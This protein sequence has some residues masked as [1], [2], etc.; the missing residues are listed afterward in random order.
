MRVIVVGSGVVG[1]TS[2]YYMARAGAEVVVLD[3]NPEPAM[4]ASFA[5]AGSMTASRSGPWASPRTLVKALKGYF[6]DDAAFR[7]RLAADPKLWTWLLGFAVSAFS[8]NTAAK[9]KAM[10]ELA[11]ANAIERERIDADLALEYGPMH[12][13]LL[14]LYH[15][16]DDFERARHDLGTLRALGINV[17]ALDASAC[18]VAE[19]AVAWD[20]LGVCGGL[21]ARDDTTA[22]CR[23]FTLALADRATAA[24]VQFRH[25]TRVQGIRPRHQGMCEV[26]LQGDVLKADAL[27]IAAGL[28]TTKLVGP[29]GVRLP[30]YPVKGYSISART[31]G[32]RQP[33]LTVAHEAK[34]VFVS[35][36]NGGLRAAGIADITGYDLAIDPVRVDVLRRIL[37]ALYPTAEMSGTLQVWSGLRAM[38]HDGPPLIFGIPDA[39]IWINTGHGS[40]GWTFACAAAKMTCDLVTANRAE[41]QNPFFGLSKRWHG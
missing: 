26:A 11:L 21:L 27:I 17:E 25:G 13:G 3:Q 12:K 6:E 8:A 36:M 32:G 41:S 22:D 10:I 37:S 7:L 16:T 23:S 40:L 5:N 33:M 39:G 2:A 35:P 4:G 15:N 14:T 29:L 18:R 9:R 38:T 1:V 34:K 31:G 24:G 19:P 28:E 30:I 20:G